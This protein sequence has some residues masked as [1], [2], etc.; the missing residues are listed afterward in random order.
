MALR[1][2]LWPL[3][4]RSLVD[5]FAALLLNA[6]GKADEARAH[7]IAYLDASRRLSSPRDIWNA[8]IILVDTEVVAGN[9]QPAAEAAREM[10]ARNRKS[11]EPS[12]TG[13]GLRI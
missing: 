6:L 13:R 12:E 4:N 10:L 11:P 1:D 2:P 9:V 8:Q 7:A 3:W 5:N